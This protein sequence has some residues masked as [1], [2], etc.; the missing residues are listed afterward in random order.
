M[1]LHKKLHSYLKTANKT[2]V[3]VQDIK[4]GLQ[5]IDWMCDSE[6]SRYEALLRI[7]PA[8]IELVDLK[9][10]ILQYHL[11]A[12]TV[13]ATRLLQLE[14][15]SFTLQADGKKIITSAINNIYVSVF[16]DRD[17]FSQGDKR[18]EKDKRD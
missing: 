3:S 8:L 11:K 16:R 6:Q 13:L 17:K 2:P 4:R 7:M 15:L 10:Q 5:R 14:N 9:G 18:R 1:K 12:K